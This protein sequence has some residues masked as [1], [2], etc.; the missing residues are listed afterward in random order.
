[1]PKTKVSSPYHT[2]E[3]A[4]VYIIELEENITLL[5][6][7]VRQLESAMAKIKYTAV[8]T[9]LPKPEEEND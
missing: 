7:R 8:M 6:T 9:E 4:E 1:M 2:F 3:E 5:R